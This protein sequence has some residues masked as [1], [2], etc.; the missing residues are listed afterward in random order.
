MLGELIG[1]T[2]GKRIVRRVLSSAP[3]KVEVSFEDAGKMLGVEVNGF[4]TYV[5]EVRA[6]G[7]L[8]GEGSGAYLSAAGDMLAW[9]GSGLGKL[10]EGGAVSYRGILYY[11]TTSTK[12]ARLNTVAGVFEY[13]VD[14]KGTTHAK[15][16]EWK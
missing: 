10:G 7:S 5:S 6:D 14:S 1:E 13:E 12:L 16:W 4:G 8:Y 15:V 11:R 2:R 9:Q 3:L